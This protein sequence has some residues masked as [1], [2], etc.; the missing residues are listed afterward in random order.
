[1]AYHP[2]PASFQPSRANIQVKQWQ[3]PSPLTRASTV[4]VARCPAESEKKK[5]CTSAKW[6]DESGVRDFVLAHVPKS[7]FGVLIYC[8][9][10]PFS[11]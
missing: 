10:L 11:A 7:S 3:T 8:D 1:M 6:E 4:G 5:N 2:L 9:I